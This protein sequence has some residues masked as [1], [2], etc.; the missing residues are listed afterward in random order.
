[1]MNGGCLLLVGRGHVSQ[2]T[3]CQGGDRQADFHGLVA[4]GPV[5]GR[6]A[7]VGARR[8]AKGVRVPSQR[9]LGDVSGSRSGTAGR[10]GPFSLQSAAAAAKE[11]TQM[12]KNAKIAAGGVAVGL[13]L[14]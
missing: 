5:I 4:R 9:D 10:A 14:L 12:S 2:V 11:A 3:A 6:A 7:P 13:I 8:G 1:M